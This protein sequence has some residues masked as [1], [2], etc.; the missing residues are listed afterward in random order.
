MGFLG[1][2]PR[3][4]Q[5][6]ATLPVRCHRGCQRTHRD[7]DRSS[8]GRRCLRLPTKLSAPDSVTANSAA[9]RW[10][11]P[12]LWVEKDQGG[13]TCPAAGRQIRCRGRSFTTLDLSLRDS[14]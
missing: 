2:D 9:S 3:T 12:I 4:R 13:A 8:K 7:G 1:S 6:M 11:S 10:L 14:S 5:Q